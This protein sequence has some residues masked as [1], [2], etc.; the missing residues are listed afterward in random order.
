[1]HIEENEREGNGQSDPEDNQSEDQAHQCG[2]GREVAKGFGTE[3]ARKG[4]LFH[5][6]EA[7]LFLRV[8]EIGDLCHHTELCLSSRLMLTA[9]GEGVYAEGR[10]EVYFVV[11]LVHGIAYGG[12]IAVVD[13]FCGGDEIHAG[14]GG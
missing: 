9:E 2:Y 10:R 11:L 3:E 13:A 6:A 1:M 8:K 5:R 14:D 4:V 7:V 12:E